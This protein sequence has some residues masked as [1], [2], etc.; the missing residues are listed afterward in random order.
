MHS[1]PGVCTEGKHFGLS[2]LGK[3]QGM[4]GRLKTQLEP[5]VR[6][7]VDFFGALFTLDTNGRA[8]IITLVLCLICWHRE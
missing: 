8:R 5:R 1:P 4:I 3:V 6:G 7:F 2:V